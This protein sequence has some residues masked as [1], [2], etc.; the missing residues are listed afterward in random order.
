MQYHDTQQRCAKPEG[1]L[2]DFTSI[3]TEYCHF[4]LHLLSS[5]VVVLRSPR[6]SEDARRAVGSPTD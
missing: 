4:I 1:R 3:R 5:S 6:K 2:Q